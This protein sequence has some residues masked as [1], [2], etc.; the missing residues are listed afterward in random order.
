MLK[1]GL[2]RRI[3]TGENTNP[4]NDNWLP[5][6]GLLR[7]VSCLSDDPPGRV[8]DL[9]DQASLCWDV[10]KLKAVFLPMDVEVI[11]K[12]PIYTRRQEDFWGWHYDCRGLFTVRSAYKMLI[13]TRERR[14]AWLQ[15]GTTTSNMAKTEK[16]WSTL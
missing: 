12:I 5:R 8:A 1:Q 11:Q 14:E 4:C 7:P 2:I 10:E 15:G 6:D 9:I 3:G 13:S 16:E